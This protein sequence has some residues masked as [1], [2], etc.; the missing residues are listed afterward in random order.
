MHPFPVDNIMGPP[1]YYSND[2][3]VSDYERALPGQTHT[4]PV[5]SNQPTK[6][7]PVTITIEPIPEK[8][9]STDQIQSNHPVEKAPAE[10]ILTE[11]K[12]IYLDDNQ[13][14]KNSG[15]PLRKAVFDPLDNFGYPSDFP[16]FDSYGQRRRQQQP[17]L[18]VGQ[19]LRQP[20]TFEPSKIYRNQI[21]QP[22][23]Q[24]G[25]PLYQPQQQQQPDLQVGHPLSQTDNHLP[26][27][28]SENNNVNVDES[29][30]FEPGH[31]D[32]ITGR[33]HRLNYNPRTNLYTSWPEQQRI[34]DTLRYYQQSIDDNVHHSS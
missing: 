24:P 17:N 27:Y 7:G 1:M 25:R 4:L 15:H 29:S 8:A 19:P 5:V 16:E 30:E 20:N 11:S 3:I 13:E 33:G 34:D 12:I 21:G 28:G 9:P 10:S 22:L 14:D 32:F 2:N 31:P 18:Q 26:I 6:S 23:H